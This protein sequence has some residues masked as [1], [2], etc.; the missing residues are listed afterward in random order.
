M[1]QL[2][3]MR[4][5]KGRLTSTTGSCRGGCRARRRGAERGRGGRASRGWCLRGRSAAPGHWLAA[6]GSQ[7]QALDVSVFVFHREKGKCFSVQAKLCTNCT[8]LSA[9]CKFFWSGSVRHKH[10]RRRDELDKK[11]RES[12][13]APPGNAARCSGAALPADRAQHGRTCVFPGNCNF[14]SSGSESNLSV[15]GVRK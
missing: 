14:L 5:G 3:L 6:A 8:F 10:K 2:H 11:T 1:F 12:H 9:A 13:R 7:G 15:A 4:L